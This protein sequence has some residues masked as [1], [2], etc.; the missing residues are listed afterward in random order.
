MQADIKLEGSDDI[1]T[2]FS[3]HLD[4]L[5]SPQN[6]LHRK[7]QIDYICNKM[8]ETKTPTTVSLSFFRFLFFKKYI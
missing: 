8:K 6:A 7:I 5:G 4:S 1:V 3:S 2:V